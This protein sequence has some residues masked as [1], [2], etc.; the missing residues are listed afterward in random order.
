MIR[1]IVT[2]AALTAAVFASD[3]YEKGFDAFEDGDINVA[4][5]A[6]EKGSEQGEVQSQVMLGLLYAR[7]DDVDPDSKK[8][9]KW[10]AKAFKDEDETLHITI[11]LV[12][13]KNRGSSAEDREAVELFEKAIDGEGKVAQYHLGMLFLSGSGVDKDMKK[14]AGLIRKSKAA[15]YAKAKSAWEEHGL[16]RY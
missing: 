4:I 5:E 15:G 8:A 2:A 6:W 16:D 12:Y 9:A 13:Y 10:L 3:Y 11:G 1:H 14:A 7:G